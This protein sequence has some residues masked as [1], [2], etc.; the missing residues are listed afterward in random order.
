MEPMYY[1]GLDVHKQKISYCAKDVGGKIYAEGR[2]P[3]TRLDLNRW[4]KT[5]P[6]PWSAALEATRFSGWIYDQLKPHAA[7]LKVAHPLMLRAIA[8][9]KK[10]PHR[11]QQD[12]RLPAL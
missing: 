4:M 10:R 2:I 9:A 11:R 12:L 7:E 1:I 3:A 5:L 8:A 6:Q